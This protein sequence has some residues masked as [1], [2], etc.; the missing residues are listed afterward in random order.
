MVSKNDTAESTKD[1]IL[2][3]L[4]Y[5]AF[6]TELGGVEV[7]RTA[8]RCARNKELKKEWRKYLGQTQQH[9]KCVRGV[10]VAFDLDP[11]RE[12]PG[13]K[14][15]RHIGKS[16]VKAM[17]MALASSSPAAAELVAT[18]CVVSAETKD[19]Q[20]WELLGKIVERDGAGAHA[21]L[22][23]ACEATEDEE[24]ERIY[25]SQG[26]SRELWFQALRPD[27]KLP[28]PEETQD[29][30]TARCAISHAATTGSVL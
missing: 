9:V 12:T 7:Y 24:D 28:P 26:W 2:H 27:A 5:Q 17:E 22:A 18:E 19:H 20:N 13:R 15:V 25:H 14:V 29:V 30:K 1:P 3:D 21:K 16:L 23:A 11:D 8:V 4:L 6:E 10:L